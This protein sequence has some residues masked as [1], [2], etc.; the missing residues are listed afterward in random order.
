MDDSITSPLM[1]HLTEAQVDGDRL[2]DVEEAAVL[3]ESKGKAVQR[4]QNVRPLVTLKHVRVCRIKRE[5]E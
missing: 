3:A 4:L 5:R 1:T 2:G